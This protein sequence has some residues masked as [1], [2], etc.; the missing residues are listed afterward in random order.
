MLRKETEWVEL[1]INRTSVLVD[2]DPD[3]MRAGVPEVDGFPFST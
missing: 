3:R 1:V 2:A